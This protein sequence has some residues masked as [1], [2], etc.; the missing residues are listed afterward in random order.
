MSRHRATMSPS[1]SLVGSYVVLQINARAMVAEYADSPILAL[2]NALGTQKYV[3]LVEKEVQV[4][5]CSDE[6]IW[7]MYRVSL[8]GR[9]TRLRPA[10][11]ASLS[12]SSREGRCLPIYPASPS[13]HATAYAP[14]RPSKSFPKHDC[15][16]R[17]GI[18][19]LVR[20]HRQP[21]QARPQWTLSDEQMRRVAVMRRN[22]DSE[23]GADGAQNGSYAQGP[24]SEAASEASEGTDATIRQP[25]A[26]AP[27]KN[28]HYPF[29]VHASSG[30]GAAV[31]DK[32]LPFLPPP[33][34]LSPLNPN[35]TAAVARTP[36][37]QSQPPRV[38]TPNSHTTNTSVAETS[39]S[40]LFDRETARARHDTMDSASIYSNTDTDSTSTSVVVLLES[41]SASKGALTLGCDADLDGIPLVDVSFDLS[42]LA[43]IPDPTQF[44][45]E[46]D[47]VA[48]LVHKAETRHRNTPTPSVLS[49][50]DSESRRLSLTLARAR[51]HQ[52]QHTLVSSRPISPLTA[53]SLPP[54]PAQAPAPAKLRKARSRSSYRPLPADARSVRS[55]ART[56]SGGRE[57]QTDDS[58]ES[59]MQKEKERKRGDS[60]SFTILSVPGNAD[61]VALA[62]ERTVL[63]WLAALADTPVRVILKQPARAVRRWVLCFVRKGRR[64]REG[65]MKGKTAYFPSEDSDLN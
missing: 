8:V 43:V 54:V 38:F 21:H 33:S 10:A 13:A 58:V 60:F 18:E 11:P 52:S 45:E 19:T 55:R 46:R 39:V 62:G 5:S 2:A 47:V 41:P 32:Q 22:L 28:E 31:R 59:E 1:D 3:A 9:H 61:G 49:A 57:R 20:V 6:P 7:R 36:S 15:C 63:A 42:E 35:F 27:H 16:H 29:A 37:P 12:S 64:R 26:L 14:V 25:V 65:G 44:L 56:I 50:F 17:P 51:S 53:P 40:E 30:S 23:D 34:P 48:Q 4:A 24:K